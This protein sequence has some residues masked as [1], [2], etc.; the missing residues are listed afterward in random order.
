MPIDVKSIMSPQ[1]K[2]WIFSYHSLTEEFDDS[3]HTDDVTLRHQTCIARKSMLSKLAKRE[4]LFVKNRKLE[5]R[6]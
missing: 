5:L 6:T 3:D 1:I 2:D 4:R